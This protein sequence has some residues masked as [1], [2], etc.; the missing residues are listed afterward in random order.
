MSDTSHTATVAADVINSM[1]PAEP[2][3]VRSNPS[4]DTLAA[5][6]GDIAQAEI[7]HLLRDREPD[8]YT[9][10]V[11]AINVHRADQRGWEP[12]RYGNVRRQH[13][14]HASITSKAAREVIDLQSAMDGRTVKPADTRALAI[15]RFVESNPEAGLPVG[16]SLAEPGT[17]EHYHAA[18]AAIDALIRQGRER[19]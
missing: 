6:R 19:R 16:T 8:D 12:T 13:D 5:H 2:A 9:A 3:S 11:A 18:N 15:Q 4:T 7:A 14:P 10:R 1:A 17:P